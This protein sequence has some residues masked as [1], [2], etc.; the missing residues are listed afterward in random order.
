MS[1]GTKTLAADSKSCL[2]LYQDV[3]DR[4]CM[5]AGQAEASARVTER[6]LL[7]FHLSLRI[8]SPV[9]IADTTV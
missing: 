9:A 2:K 5:Q 8:R 6:Q 3:V 7:D 1:G 4:L